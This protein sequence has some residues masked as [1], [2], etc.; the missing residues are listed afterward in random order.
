MRQ[1]PAEIAPL[2]DKVLAEQLHGLETKLGAA[3]KDA[4]APAENKQ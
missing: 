4:A 3:S 2:V 1:K